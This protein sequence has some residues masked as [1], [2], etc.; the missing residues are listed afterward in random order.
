MSDFNDDISY[1][2]EL[3]DKIYSPQALEGLSTGYSDL[4]SVSGG[5]K[6]GGLLILGGTTGTGKS[7]FALNIL[8]NLAKRGIQVEYHDLENSAMISHQRLI[9]IW[10]GKSR[11]AFVENKEMAVEAMYE[12]T[13]FITYFD[14][15]F[16][17]SKNKKESLFSRVIQFA[18]VSK[19]RVILIDP[20]QSLENE[21]DGSKI[22]NEQGKYVRELKEL[23][24]KKNKTIILCHHMRKGAV[25]SGEW[26]KDLE[27]ATEQ[28]Y[29]IPSLEDMRGSGKIVDYATDVWGIVRTS[30]SQTKVGRGNTLVRIL[31]NRT[32]LK[33]DIKMFFDEDTLQFHQTMK[34]KND[35]VSNFFGGL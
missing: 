17:Q 34:V 16:L 4:D 12:Y 29:Q 15:E 28:R 13:D 2:E 31:K 5:L 26:V 6:Q 18:N 20:L 14:H 19:A 8:V 1:Y 21:L 32:G 11:N 35:I 30:G 23:A 27:D 25:R 10:T 7:L 9:S 22:L 33:G 3:V 24:Q